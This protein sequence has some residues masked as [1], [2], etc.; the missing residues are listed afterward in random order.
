MEKQKYYIVLCRDY[1]DGKTVVVTD[2]GISYNLDQGKLF[3][4]I[5]DAMRAVIEYNQITSYKFE[6]EKIFV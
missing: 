2:S 5:G 4:V 6:I 1:I 3:S